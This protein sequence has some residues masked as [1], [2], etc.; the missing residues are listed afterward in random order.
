MGGILY[1]YKKNLKNRAKKAVRKPVTYFYIV[2]ILFYIVCMPVAFKVLIDE[3]GWGTPEVL[4]A[5]FTVITF[6]L[7]P[8]NLISY[9]KRKG[10]L[11]RK[12]DV[13]FLF[14]SPISPK[15][16]LLYAH[17]KTLFIN[18][19]IGIVVTL[20][21]Y[22]LF[23]ASLLQMAVYFLVSMVLQNILEG[24]LMILLYGSERLG[25]KGRRAA[26]L[27]SY[28][29]IGA[30]VVIALIMYVL[31]GL[32]VENV[33]R[34]L[35]SDAV[36]MVPL[37]GWYIGLIH[38]IFMGPT[39]VNVIC[40]VLY[41]ICV[42][43]LAVWA[44]KM[45][46][47][48]D[49]Y[50]DAMK[51]AEDYEELRQ[52]KMDGEMA[53][54]GKKEKFGKA[55]VVYKGGGAKALFYKQLLEYK[56][57]KLFFFDNTTLLM[58]ALGAFIGYMWAENMMDYKEFIL[59]LVMGYMVLCMSAVGGKWSKEIKSPYTFLIPDSPMRKLWYATVMEHI[60]SVICGAICAIPAG[61]L[62]QV[63][64]VQIVLCILLYT[65]LQACKIY[66]TVVAE[67]MVGNVLG[68]TG[69]QLF[70]MLLQGIVLGMA[71]TGAVLGILFISMEAGYLLMIGILV[72]LA[73]ALM[74]VANTCFD[75]ME[76]TEG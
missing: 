44:L 9:A 41:L 64:P 69:K 36:Q 61:I 21:G 5:L 8:A 20:A 6:W 58:M 31:Y 24:S 25:E 59:P 60:K 34:F 55:T 12:G 63:S 33:L 72:I 32:N 3:Y 51:F 65:C 16:V 70:V 50:E 15:H 49:Y 2:L 56:K 17:I 38:L 29:L 73:F 74:T 47:S 48:G 40:S 7:I 26:V 45:P 68:K 54:L 43:V 14:T 57:C 37:V 11:F 39:T 35:H 22:F 75:K 71:G 23:H 67:V 19:L 52:K 28:A 62:L 42:A 1:L 27:V 30:F 18:T 13:H 4:T 10:L 46:C 76:V 53:R 66:N